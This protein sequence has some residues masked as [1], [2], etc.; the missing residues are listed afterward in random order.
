MFSIDVMVIICNPINVY[1]QV[2]PL[3][4]ASRLLKKVL[5]NAHDWR[6]HL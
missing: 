3:V 4:T 6:G 2:A 1:I 5:D